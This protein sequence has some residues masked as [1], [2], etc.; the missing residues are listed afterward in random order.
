MSSSEFSG[1]DDMRDCIIAIQEGR[2]T[3]AV[4]EFKKVIENETPS[5]KFFEIIQWGLSKFGYLPLPDREM[6]EGICDEKYRTELLELVNTS[7]AKLKVV[8][9]VM[10]IVYEK[11]KEFTLFNMIEYFNLYAEDA[12]I[13]LEKIQEISNH[14]QVEQEEDTKEQQQQ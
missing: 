4:I 9:C 7:P 5:C 2:I 11:E 10:G 8:F 6:D 1:H 3:D 12:N 14:A 13:L